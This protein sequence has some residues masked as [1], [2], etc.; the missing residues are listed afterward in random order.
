MNKT[1]QPKLD[2]IEKLHGNAQYCEIYGE[3][4]NKI[5]SDLNYIHIIEGFL[6][7]LNWIIEL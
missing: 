1:T 6:L 2:G 5:V 4:L 3:R 7:H